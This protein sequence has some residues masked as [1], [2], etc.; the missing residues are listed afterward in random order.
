MGN[1]LPSDGILNH[2][3]LS[4]N[5]CSGCKQM[6][7]YYKGV[8]TIKGPE[9]EQTQCKTCEDKKFKIMLN[10]VDL[11][12]VVGIKPTNNIKI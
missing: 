5:Q 6:F 8:I 1:N 4:Q 11:D 9:L 10:S 12:N 3:V 7:N 2:G